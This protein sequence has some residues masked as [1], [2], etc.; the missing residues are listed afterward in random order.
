MSEK[1]TNERCAITA[2]TN[3]SFFFNSA[4]LQSYSCQ[5]WDPMERTQLI[6]LVT[7]VG[8]MPCSFQPTWYGCHGTQDWRE[9]NGQTRWQ[10]RE[11]EKTSQEADIN[12]GAAF[13][14]LQQFTVQSWYEEFKK[15]AQSKPTGTATW[16]PRCCNG[17]LSS[18]IPPGVPRQAQSAIHQLRLNRLTS[19][20]SYQA[21]I[22]QIT[23]P[24]CP[25]CGTGEETA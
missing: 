11:V 4:H 9:M 24:I 18:R 8:R 5:S 10:K 12:I 19:T 13:Q 1:V 17:Q 6:S 23:S 25:H 15:A 7:S 2:C 21:F 3:N 14:H 22:E 20:A 16:H